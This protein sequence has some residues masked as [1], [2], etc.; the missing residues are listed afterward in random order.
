MTKHNRGAPDDAVPSYVHVPCR[1]ARCSRR[2]RPCGNR[3]DRHRRPDER[4]GRSV[5]RHG[6]GRRADGGRA[7]QRGRRRGRQQARSGDD[8]RRM[9][10]EAGGGRREQDR[11]PEDQVRD[12]PRVLGLDDSGVGYLRERGRR[13]DHAF[14]DRAAA[15]RR[16]EAQVHLPHDRAR[17]SA[18]AGR[19][20]VHHQQ[21]QAEEGRRAARQAVVRPGHRLGGEEGA[22]RGEGARRDLRRASTRAT[23]ITR[24]SS[25]S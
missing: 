11:Q 14:R 9:R 17:R 1:D 8:G 24:R 15:H 13:D 10:A 4:L 16:Q 18:G 2:R 20:A 22:R 7:G 21:G 5:R 12:R 25:R 23:P 19:R 6:Q 3:E